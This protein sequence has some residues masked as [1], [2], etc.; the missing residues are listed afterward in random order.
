M[1]ETALITLFTVLI[2]LLIGTL[3]IAGLLIT[4]VGLPGVWLVLIGILISAIY[5]GFEQI[6]PGILILFTILALISSLADNLLVILGAKYTGGSRWSMVGA[7][8]G[9]MIGLFVGNIFGLILGPFIGAS[10]FEV[11][12]AKKDTKSAMKAGFGTF[13]GFLLSILLKFGMGVLISI[14]WLSMLIG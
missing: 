10:I 7:V 4:L 5:T 8:I 1:I 2:W 11:I 14:I 12:F 9:A 3:V 13:L 6:G